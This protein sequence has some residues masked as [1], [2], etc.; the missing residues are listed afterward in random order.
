VRDEVR[1][2]GTLRPDRG[3]PQTDLVQVLGTDGQVLTSGPALAGVPP[4]VTLDAVRSHA[5]SS[6][7]GWSSTDRMVGSPER[8]CRSARHVPPHAGTGA[9]GGGL[10]LRRVPEAEQPV[11]F[12]GLA[13]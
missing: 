2:D 1:K 3:S 13:Q 7:F 10:R 11:A 6:G 9:G 12:Q 4:L 5:S 8:C